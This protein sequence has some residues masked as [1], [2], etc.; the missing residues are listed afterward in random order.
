MS[1]HL[2][3]AIVILDEAHNIEDSARESASFKLTETDLANAT[4]DLGG[5]IGKEVK[6]DDHRPLYLLCQRS[7]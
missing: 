4:N 6:L 2:G 3:G 7:G 5:L 1:I